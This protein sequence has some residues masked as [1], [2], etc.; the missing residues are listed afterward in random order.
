MQ[1]ACQSA[2]ALAARMAG[3]MEWRSDLRSAK[4]MGFQL[5]LNSGAS[6][7][8]RKEYLSGHQSAPGSVLPMGDPWAH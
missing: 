2:L 7:A 1:K 5:E 8:C 6:K 4:E 3:Q